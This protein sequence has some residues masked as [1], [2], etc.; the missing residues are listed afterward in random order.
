VHNAELESRTERVLPPLSDD[1][2]DVECNSETEFSFVIPC[3]DQNLVDSTE[4][5]AYRDRQVNNC[6]RASCGYV[7][8][9]S[10]NVNMFS[11]VPDDCSS[12]Q[13]EYAH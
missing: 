13:T 5:I 11:S 7:R 9:V 2:D 12:A 10:S 1:C 6:D 3:A 8:G 4:D